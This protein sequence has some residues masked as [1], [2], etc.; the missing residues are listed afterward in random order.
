MRSI[1][2]VQADK[3]FLPIYLAR[4]YL[5]ASFSDAQPKVVQEDE[6]E[7]V[8]DVAFVVSPGAQYKVSNLQIAG[9]R[10]VPIENLKQMIHLRPGE[11]ANVVQLNRDVEAIKRLYGSRGYMAA[12]VVAEP[13][14]SDADST[15]KYFLHLQEG[16]L[17]KMGDLDIRGLDSVITQRV[18]AAWKLRE[19]D[20][21]DGTYP[22]K[23][24]PR[25]SQS[26][27]LATIGTSWFTNR[28]RTKTRRWTCPCTSSASSRDG[29]TVGAADNRLNLRGF[30]GG[31][32]FRA[33]SN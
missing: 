7:T 21:Y 13:E 16:D 15:V 29:T 27:R 33:A 6:D 19:G 26:S 1:L 18:V 2:R 5:K 8:V 24:H 23:I 11:P 12:Q 9:M 10:A 28:W 20:T 4:G 22:A 31:V 30:S 17:Y 3:N 25:R 32:I 14:I